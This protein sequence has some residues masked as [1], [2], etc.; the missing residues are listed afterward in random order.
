M[1]LASNYTTSEALFKMLKE[2]PREPQEVLQEDWKR[3]IKM[4]VCIFWIYSRES[5]E[6]QEINDWLEKNN[7]AI[8]W[9]WR[10]SIDSTDMEFTTLLQ[11]NKK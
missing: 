5:K 3:L 10:F 6:I 2:L 8:K 7:L 9:D 11:K 4:S 1:K